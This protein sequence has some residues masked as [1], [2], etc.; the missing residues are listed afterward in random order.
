MALAVVEQLNVPIRCVGL[1]EKEE[2]LQDFSAE[3]FINAL[4]SSSEEDA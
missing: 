1:G 2:D 3:D 4:F